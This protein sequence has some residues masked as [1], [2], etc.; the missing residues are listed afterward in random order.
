MFN[1]LKDSA[2]RLLVIA[3]SWFVSMNGLDILSSLPTD[4]AFHETSPFMR[5]VDG[6]FWLYH[7][8][9][10]KLLYLGILLAFS[11]VVFGGIRSISRAAASIAASIV[12]FYEGWD[13]LSNA[14]LPNF[15]IYIHWYVVDV[16]EV[17]N[18]ILGI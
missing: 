11:G 14:V 7:A 16:R 18:R 8:I 1:W 2:N 10:V 3:F 13:V 6:T 15:F 9:I 5:H 12:P 4:P 17:L